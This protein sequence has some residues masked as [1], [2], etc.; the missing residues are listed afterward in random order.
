MSKDFLLAIIMFS[1][2]DIGLFLLI[3][4]FYKKFLIKNG[5]EL[6]ILNKINSYVFGLEDISLL[7][8]QIGFLLFFSGPIILIFFYD[9]F[10]DPFF[11]NLTYLLIFIIYIG[12][13]F[14]IVWNNQIKRVLGFT[15][16]NKD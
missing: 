8:F 5:F 9:F 1:G 4:P 16:V 10:Q 14:L 12:I 3:V 13:F 15:T 6:K 7:S 11:N 2:L